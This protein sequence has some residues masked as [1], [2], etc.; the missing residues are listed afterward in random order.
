M[1]GERPS[2]TTGAA[3]MAKDAKRA[4][5][6][7]KIDRKVIAK[8]L[9]CALG[10]ALV[11]GCRKDDAPPAPEAAE[12]VDTPAHSKP[13]EPERSKIDELLATEPVI[14][15]G[16][17]YKTATAEANR[18]AIEKLMAAF[19]SP[20]GAVASEDLCGQ[21][22]ICGPGLWAS[23]KDDTELQKI[24]TGVTSFRVPTG[25]QVQVLAG[26][27]LQTEA[28]VATFWQAFARRFRPEPGAIIRRPTAEEISLYWAM[29]PYDITEPIFVIESPRYVLLVALAGDDAKILWVDDYKNLRLSK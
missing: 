17:V 28:E 1:Q 5:I 2:G 7:M 4:V 19:L 25:D 21:T 27:L 26:K 13:A 29:I 3:T 24:E 14:P 16:V 20:D 8:M 10:V 23:F 18:A 12:S 11:G 15:A 9:L 22:L 6:V